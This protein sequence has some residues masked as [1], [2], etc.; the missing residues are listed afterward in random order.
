MDSKVSR[1]DGRISK[2]DFLKGVH[3]LQRE[4]SHS[5]LRA[6]RHC[7]PMHAEALDISGVG[8]RRLNIIVLSVVFFLTGKVSYRRAAMARVRGGHLFP[9]PMKG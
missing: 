6:S 3:S 1:E 8:R 9:P 5:V 7:S 2:H 4:V